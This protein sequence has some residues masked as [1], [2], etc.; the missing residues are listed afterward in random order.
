MAIIG[1]SVNIEYKLLPITLNED[2]SSMINFSEGFTLDGT[3]T[4]VKRSELPLSVAE[5]QGILLTQTTP[6]KTR[7]EDLAEALYT[8][9]ISKGL[10]SGTIV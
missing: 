5:T 7:R 9:L 10:V 6:G 8:L 2:G 1:Q 3:Y 4:V